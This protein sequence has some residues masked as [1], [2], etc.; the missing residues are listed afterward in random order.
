[1]SEEFSA[2][3]VAAAEGEGGS[4]GREGGLPG[5]GQTPATSGGFCRLI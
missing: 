2:G 4:D 1:M 5:L 3:R